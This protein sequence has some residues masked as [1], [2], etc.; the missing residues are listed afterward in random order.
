MYTDIHTYA[1]MYIKIYRLKQSL[2][3]VL[4][5]NDSMSN[6]NSSKVPFDCEV[7]S[8]DGFQ[9]RE[10]DIVIF[11][12]VRSNK[13][14]AVGFLSDERR[15]NVAITRARRCLIIV[16]DSRALQKDRNWG[17]LMKSLR[18]RNVIRNVAYPF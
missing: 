11:S 12:C 4:S 17:L 14:G 15:M 18:D 9:G 16:G 5:S 3:D 13:Y 8:I 1:H 6:G 10:K 2:L 7:N